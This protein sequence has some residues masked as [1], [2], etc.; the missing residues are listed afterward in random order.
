MFY[1]YHDKAFDHAVILPEENWTS[2]NSTFLRVVHAKC[3]RY[4]NKPETG[5]LL[6]IEPKFVTI[7]INIIKL[8]VFNRII[9]L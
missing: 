9:K 8:L 4:S 2:G 6:P 5:K 7:V 3:L 1:N